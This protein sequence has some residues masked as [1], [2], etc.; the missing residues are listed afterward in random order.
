MLDTFQLGLTGLPPL[1]AWSKYLQYCITVSK[2]RSWF[3]PE[4]CLRLASAAFA[5]SRRWEMATIKK[6]SPGLSTT[7]EASHCPTVALRRR[8]PPFPHECQ[9]GILTLRHPAAKFHLIYSISSPVSTDFRSRP[10]AVP[11]GLPPND[12]NFPAILAR[13]NDALERRASS[14]HLLP[15]HPTATSDGVAD[16]KCHSATLAKCEKPCRSMPL[17]GLLHLSQ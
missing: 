5:G 4:P 16:A 7:P 12:A 1:P 17:T 9:Y 2:M 15:A 11:S 14:A 13:R 3:R 8:L 6:K 10:S